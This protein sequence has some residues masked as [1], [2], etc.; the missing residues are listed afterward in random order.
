MDDAG[1]RDVEGHVHLGLGHTERDDGVNLLEVRLV[2]GCD[3]RVVLL[4][5][6]VGVRVGHRRHRHAVH[7]DLDTAVLA[8]LGAVHGVVAAAV[9]LL[10]GD[11]VG[12]DPLQHTPG[13]VVDG[14]PVLVGHELDQVIAQLGHHVELAARDG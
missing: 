10:A 1:D 11:Q 2:P 4:Y 5:V 8:P 3:D 12:L 6:V 9:D 7:L 14:V 13:G